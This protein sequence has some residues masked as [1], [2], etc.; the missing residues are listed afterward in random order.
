MI[1]TWQVVSVFSRHLLREKLCPDINW[2]GYINDF[3]SE[4]PYELELRYA[5]AGT[6]CPLEDETRNG[7]RNESRNPEWWEDFSQLQFQIKQNF[8]FEFV[9]RDTSEF[10]SN[11]NLNSTFYREIPASN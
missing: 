7:Q 11:Q 4:N 5:G 10:K 2:P 6:A 8:Q 3:C 1:V 9:P